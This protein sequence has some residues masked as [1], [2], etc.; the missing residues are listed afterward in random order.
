M[1]KKTTKKK[2]TK[3]ASQTASPKSPAK[4]PKS[5]ASK[6]SGKKEAGKSG[7]VKQ[8]TVK[9]KP[10]SKTSGKKPATTQ[11]GKPRKS[12]EAKNKTARTEQSAYKF[13]GTIESSKREDCLALATLMET[14]AKAP[15]E[16]WGGSIL[17]FGRIRF[18]YESGRE[19]DW[20]LVGFAPRKQN[21]ALYFMADFPQRQ[22][23]L[24]QLGKHTTGKSCVYI[25]RLGDIDLKVLGQLIT[26]SVAGVTKKFAPKG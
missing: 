23:L 4:N 10:A 19:G 8:V 20:F 6:T 25:K 11:S 5:P 9:Q 26:Q 17:G 2:T 14:L 18:V 13:L 3:Q 7:P 1:K 15:A 16:M 22:S 21:I 12:Y 24:D